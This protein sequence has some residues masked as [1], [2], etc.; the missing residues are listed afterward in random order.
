ME[1]D[2]LQVLFDMKCGHIKP[3]VDTEILNKTC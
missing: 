2:P 3:T 1:L